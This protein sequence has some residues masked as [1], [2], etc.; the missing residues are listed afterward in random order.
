[1]RDQ[2]DCVDDGG[3]FNDVEMCVTSDDVPVLPRAC[4]SVYCRELN[5]L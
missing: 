4:V 1:M 3:C 5:R 2:R